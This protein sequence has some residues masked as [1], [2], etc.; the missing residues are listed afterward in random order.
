MQNK[1]KNIQNLANTFILTKN[2]RSFRNL[3]DRLK[4]GIF[5]HCYKITKSRDLA[6]DAFL[7][8][9]SKVWEKI[10]QYN[11]DRGNF[12][13]WCYNIARNET[14]LLLKEENKY[15][16]RTSLEMEFFTS[17]ND[18][19]DIGGVYLMEEDEGNSIFKDENEFDLIYESVINEIT[20]LPEIYKDIMVDREINKM[21]YKDIAE[22]YGLKKRSVATRIRRARNK[23]TKNLERNINVF[24]YIKK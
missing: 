14:L 9:M 16:S 15:N 21:K 4:P 24:P 7:N 5:N 18:I 17:N 22:K 12:S 1:E 3:F 8:T 10:D 23:I 6:E 2:D 20:D 11:E 13:T 19:G